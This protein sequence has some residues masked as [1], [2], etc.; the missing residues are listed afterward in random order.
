MN[1][2]QN[3]DYTIFG[4]WLLVWYWC[5]IVGGVLMLLGMVLPALFTIIASF[6]LGMVYAVG[7]L[8]SIVAV[9]ISAVLDINAA[10]QMK[11]RNPRFFDTLLFGM[12]VSVGGGI[13]SNLLMLRSFRGIGGFISST[14]GSV[15]G[16][17]IGVCLCVMY[18]SKSVRVHT[19]FGGRPVQSSQYW[20]W[21]RLLPEVILSDEMPDPSKM[22]QMGSKPQQSYQPPQDSQYTQAS[23]DTSEQNPFEADK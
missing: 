18:L 8:I 4:G 22:Q 12:L 7:L 15:I 5:L 1:Q 20:A 11:A 2:N 23:S 17:A 21:I 9:C 16:L 3:Q 13:V 10:L 19:Y 14:L 6:T